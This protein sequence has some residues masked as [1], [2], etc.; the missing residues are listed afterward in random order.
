MIWDTPTFIGLA[1]SILLLLAFLMNQLHHWSEED[2]LYAVCN[3]I[4][5]LCLVIYA[6]LLRSIPFGLL[7]GVWTL[8]SLR[9]I[10]TDMRRLRAKRQKGFFGKWFRWKH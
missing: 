7:N 9:D 10:S 4:G 1:G 5:G 6:I 8:V 2:L 3:F